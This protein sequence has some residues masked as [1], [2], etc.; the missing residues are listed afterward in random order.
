MNTKQMGYAIQTIDE[1][2]EEHFPEIEPEKIEGNIHLVLNYESDMITVAH[3]KHMII[4]MTTMN[5]FEPDD[6]LT[7]EKLMR[8]LGFLQGALWSRGYFSLDTLRE[9]NVVEK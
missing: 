2:L 5:N 9:M 3:L 6:Q 7:R 4:E 1:W 8:W